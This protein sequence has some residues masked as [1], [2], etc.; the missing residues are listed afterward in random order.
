MLMKMEHCRLN[1]LLDSLEFEVWSRTRNFKLQTPNSLFFFFPASL[2]RFSS[3]NTTHRAFFLQKRTVAG[4]SAPKFS[5]FD[6]QQTDAEQGESDK[7]KGDGNE[8]NRKHEP[9]EF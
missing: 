5:F 3:A 7:H 8:E 2:A 9:E 4:A 6:K 1:L